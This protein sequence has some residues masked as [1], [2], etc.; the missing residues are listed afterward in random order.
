VT[1]L[2][3]I[4]AVVVNWNTPS[5][6]IRSVEALI[7]DGV[8]PER[9]VV[10]DNGSDDSS[11]EQFGDRLAGCVLV[12]LEQNIGYGRASNRGARELPG[13]HYLFVNNDAFVHRSGSV[14]RLLACLEDERV[15]IAVP[16]LLNVDLT[17]QP[18]V[19]PVHSPAVALVRASGLSRLVPNRWQP[20]WSTHWDHG[21]AREVEAVVGAV[22]LVRGE[23]WDELGG[24]DDRIYMYAED[25]DLCWRARRR[26][27][28]VWFCAECEFVHVGNI[29]GR[30]AWP[31]PR[32]GE[33]IGRSEAAMI[34]RNLPPWSAQLTLWLIGAGIAGRWLV[35]RL[36]GQKEAADSLRGSLRGFLSR[37]EG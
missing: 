34:R 37:S 4:T 15:G 27:W 14:A 12:H 32:R 33:M 13:E 8:P 10:V 23:T 7:D 24:Y 18:S 1:A 30:Q 20:S 5:Y 9:V 2:E 21:S 35:R 36:L 29:S 26:G 28:K 22:L 19:S 3:R 31:D 11:Y 25:L 17:L 6:T 16:K